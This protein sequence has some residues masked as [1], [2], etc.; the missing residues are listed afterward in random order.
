MIGILAGLGLNSKD[1]KNAKYAIV[2]AN[3]TSVYNDMLL[4]VDGIGNNL[5]I[6][7]R[8]LPHVKSKDGSYWMS[9]YQVISLLVGLALNS[10]VL[11]TSMRLVLTT[12]ERKAIESATIVWPKILPRL[13]STA[14]R[15]LA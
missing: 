7:A 1:Q 14:K 4:L 11:E 10:R 3:N 2:A 9:I 13:Y 15:R 6:Y 8:L 12:C 5:D